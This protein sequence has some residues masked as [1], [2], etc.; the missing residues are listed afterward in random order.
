MIPKK[1]K[2]GVDMG[3]SVITSINELKP[4]EQTALLG[5]LHKALGEVVPTFS[6]ES[7]SN[8]KV[9]NAL[10]VLDHLL[11]EQGKSKN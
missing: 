2:T 7:L 4:D 8:P 1:W 11:T 3:L 6:E 5:A 10:N 9:L